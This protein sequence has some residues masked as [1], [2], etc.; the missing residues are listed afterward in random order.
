M[1]LVSLMVEVVI[2]GTVLF[3]PAD[4]LSSA[5]GIAGLDLANCVTDVQGS[6]QPRS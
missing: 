2:V 1:M 4:L 5:C 3:A 6:V